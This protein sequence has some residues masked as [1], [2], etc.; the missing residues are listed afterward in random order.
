MSNIKINAFPT[1]KQYTY[2]GGSAVFVLDF[3][4]FENTDIYVY[5]SNPADNGYQEDPQN[6]I[7]QGVDYNVTGAG[8]ASGGEVTINPGYG[9]TVGYTVTVVARMPIDRFSILETTSAITRAQYNE[10]M[11][12]LTCMIQQINTIIEQT[13][14]KYDRSE[15]VNTDRTLPNTPFSFVNLP[16]LPPGYTWV[17]N[18]AGTGLTTFNTGGGGGSGF[19]TAAHPGMRPS[20]A[21]WTGTDF[22]LTDSNI[23]IEDTTFKPLTP[24]D[25]INIDDTASALGWPRHG[26]ADRDPNPQNGMVYY[27]TD[28]G[29]YY[30]YFGGTWQR[31]LFGTSNDGT[32]EIIIQDNDFEPTEVVRRNKDTNLYVRAL[33]D[34]KENAAVCGIVIAATATQFTIKYIGR[35]TNPD[36]DWIDG[37]WYFL[38]TVNAGEL[39]TVEPTTNGKI[40]LPLLVATANNSGIFFNMRGL[41]VGNGSDVDQGEEIIIETINQPGHGFNYIGMVLKPKTTTPGEYEKAQATTLPLAF[42]TVMIREIIDVDNF[43]VQQVGKMANFGTIPPVPGGIANPAF[44]MTL[45]VPYYLSE[46]N[47][48]EITTVQPSAPNFSQPK[49]IPTETGAG[50]NCPMKPTVQSSTGGNV[51]PVILGSFEFNGE[52]EVE[53]PNVFDCDYPYVKIVG[54]DLQV[55][56]PSQIYMYVESGGVFVTGN[57]Y[58][59]DVATSLNGLDMY[60]FSTTSPWINISRGYPNTP[61]TGDNQAPGATYNKFKFEI[62]VLAPCTA[63]AYKFWTIQ[64][65]GLYGNAPYHYMGFQNFGSYPFGNAITGLKFISFDNTNP[66]AI[67]AG[68][69]TIYG[70]KA[71][72]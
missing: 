59:N 2:A 47:A 33:G 70:T 12:R 55:A 57:N 10:D 35:V 20:I 49:F 48:G 14:P 1:R 56:T 66:V 58:R 8:L 4:F 46:T 61:L 5:V 15:Y 27:D 3:P 64:S 45:G 30:A 16:W 9:L 18:A 40:S 24:G 65:Q 51:G 43:K 54:L 71:L 32:E 72:P 60:P 36:A 67:T 17:G 21:L 37:N 22:V 23:N 28:L 26:T 39:T 34:S 11:N 13:I 7:V 25:P 19:V 38:S 29:G 41:V 6:L 62:D 50:W 31:F 63:D 53:F 68:T 52:T 44:P 69:I 42:G